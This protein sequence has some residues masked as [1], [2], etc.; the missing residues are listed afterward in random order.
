MEKWRASGRRAGLQSQMVPQLQAGFKEGLSQAGHG[1]PEP[2]ENRPGPI[3]N[4]GEMPGKEGPKDARRR[5]LTSEEM[6]EL[7]HEDNERKRKVK[8]KK[9][10]FQRPFNIFRR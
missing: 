3:E 10:G 5:G 1:P 2:C 6:A 4:G 7:L 9:P 8:K